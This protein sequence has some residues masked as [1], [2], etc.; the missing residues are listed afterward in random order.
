[1]SSLDPRWLPQAVTG[2]G[3]QKEGILDAGGL[4]EGG[5]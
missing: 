5:F 1:M 3:K 2:P 4:G